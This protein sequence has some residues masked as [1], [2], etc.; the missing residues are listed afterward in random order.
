MPWEEL[1]TGPSPAD[2]TL[3]LDYIS[4]ILPVGFWIAI[5]NRHWAVVMSMLGQFL[6]LGTVRTSFCSRC[7]FLKLVANILLDDF[8]N[9]FSHFAADYF[10]QNRRTFPT[11]IQVSS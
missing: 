7:L 6:I 10:D 8:L 5:R 2:K 11:I 9:R 4:P 3:L 1:K